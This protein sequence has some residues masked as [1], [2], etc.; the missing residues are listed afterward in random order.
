MILLCVK[1]VSFAQTNAYVKSINVFDMN[2]V[3]DCVAC[4]KHLSR[5]SINVQT[6]FEDR[7]ING[8]LIIKKH[9]LIFIKGMM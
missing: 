4:D 9:F 8:S 3:L 7:T 1:C 2:N 6:D 5:L